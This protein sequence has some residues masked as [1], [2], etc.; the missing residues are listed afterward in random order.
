MVNTVSNRKNGEWDRWDL[1][2]GFRLA[3]ALPITY[4]PEEFL[5]RSALSCNAGNSKRFLFV[6]PV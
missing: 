1:N 2:P 4:V 3:L 5:Q 6:V